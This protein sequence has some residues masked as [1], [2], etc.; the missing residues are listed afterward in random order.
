MIA[1]NV[2]SR[3]TTPPDTIDSWEGWEDDSCFGHTGLIEFDL[4]S[5]L[6]TVLTIQ[7]NPD[8]NSFP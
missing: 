5:N 3:V 6:Y 2:A 7:T 8:H 4:L 1:G